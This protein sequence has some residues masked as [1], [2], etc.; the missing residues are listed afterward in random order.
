LK[1][2]PGEINNLAKKE[3]FQEILRTWR[4]KM[5]VHLSERG[6]PWVVNNDLGIIENAIT[7]SPNYPQDFFP[8]EIET[9]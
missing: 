3:E 9:N 6:A 4:Q 5:V 7:Y 8:E 2:D 1:N